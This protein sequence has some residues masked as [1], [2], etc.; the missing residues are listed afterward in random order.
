MEI[1]LVSSILILA[2]VFLFTEKMTVDM[3]GIGI[4]VALMLTRLLTPIE[5]VRGF[6]NPAVITVGAMFIISRGMI[7][8]GTVAFLAKTMIGLSR[9][10]RN[11][12]M[13]VVLLVA[14]LASA[15]I[16]NTPVV[17]LFIPI[18]LSLSCQYD[19]SPSK[20]MI[21]LSYA[22]ILGGTCT[23]IGTSTNIIV[24]DLSDLYGYG[25]LSMFELSYLGVPLALAGIAFIYLTARYV[26][27]EHAVP[28]CEL[29]ESDHRKYLAEL[30]IPRGSPVIGKNPAPFM[31]QKYPGIEVFE[32]IRYSHVFYPKEEE[33]AV[34]AADDLLLVKGALNDLV[35]ILND[36]VVELS[37]SA[38][39]FNFAA[40][41]DKS[42]IVEMI[43]P[44]QSSLVGEKVRNTEL[45][46]D[47]D[48]HV[49][50]I[51]RGYLRHYEKQIHDVNLRT[52]D[53]LLVRCPEN[54][55]DDLRR[56]G[57]FIIVEDVHHEII[58]KSKARWALLIFVGIVGAASTGIA[59]I[60][61]CAV[62]GV[63]LMILTGCIKLRDAY[64]AVQGDV[65]LLI[66]GVI[67]LGAA[68]GKTGASELYAEGFLRM[69]HGAGP[70]MVLG[71]FLLLTSLSTQLLSNNAAAV[72]L[73]PIAVSTALALGVSP[74][75]FIIAVCFG[76]S[77]CF[78][79]PIGYQTNLLVFGPGNYRF[80]DYLKLGIPLNILVIG[81]GTLLIPVIWPF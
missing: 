59:D 22:S 44:P 48:F 4:I 28:V 32:L 15:F 40:P 20:L 73:L 77:A 43:V 75:P 72:L 13:L 46:R 14:A 16:N 25:K 70:A 30:K 49:M 45:H 64:R 38:E 5:A 24:S 39:V 69:F 66:V 57:D 80:R 6:A 42:L 55:L 53:I 18:I 10:N 51:K 27:P 79:T 56:T 36:K 2:L 47:P 21:P 61:A 35:A 62:T 81:M 52:G 11:L 74:K 19:F 7:R 33:G 76:A 17:V 29:S 58:L 26:M 31:A 3:V 68:M 34:T 78:S 71:G 9:G 37:Q 54:R 50:A 63:F 12:M 41:A 60:M 8:T 67:A 23:L 1:A 65:L